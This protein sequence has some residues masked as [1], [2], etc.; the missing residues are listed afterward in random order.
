[1]ILSL[2]IL[3]LAVPIGFLIAWLA[4]DELIQGRVWFQALIAVALILAVV[5][6]Y[7]GEQVIVYSCAFISIVALISYLKSFD[8]RFAV[9]RKR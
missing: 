4:R 9:Q 3:L 6:F 1:M 7:R 2:I 5:F 8:K